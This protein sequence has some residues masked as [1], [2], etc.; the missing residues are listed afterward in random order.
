[1]S[2]TCFTSAWKS[3]VVGVLIVEW[4]RGA[5]HSG[6]SPLV[7]GRLKA[8]TPDAGPLRW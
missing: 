6:D 5:D 8:K 7:K 1:M 4:G 3:W 2:K